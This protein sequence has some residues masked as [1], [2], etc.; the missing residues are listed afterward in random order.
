MRYQNG[1][2]MTQVKLPFNEFPWCL[3]RYQKR[4]MILH[5]LDKIECS[6][7]DLSP[8][9]FMSLLPF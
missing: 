2:V 9:V 3:I 1:P 8:E 5:A 7:L 4:L 6:R